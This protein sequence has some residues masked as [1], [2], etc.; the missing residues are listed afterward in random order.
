MNEKTGTPFKELRAQMGT[1][2]RELTI[3]ADLINA[4]RHMEVKSRGC[5]GQ[6]LRKSSVTDA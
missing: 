2:N 6:T 3:T 1:H 4:R 5:P